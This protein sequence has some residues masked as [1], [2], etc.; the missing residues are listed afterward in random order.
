M[1][2]SVKVC[3]AVLFSVQ[4]LTVL[5]MLAY[6]LTIDGL[7]EKYGKTYRIKIDRINYVENGKC[8]FMLLDYWPYF[9]ALWDSNIAYICSESDGFYTIRSKDEVKERKDSD[10][11]FCFF[12]HRFPNNSEYKLKG[13][14]I[15]YNFYYGPFSET[16]NYIEIKVF[17]GNC[18]VERLY[19]GG[20]P[21]EEY[22]DKTDSDTVSFSQ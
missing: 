3:A 22:L 1:K 17:L 19:C 5:L 11:V 10:Y 9:N 21:I 6:G 16:D 14:S 8:D 7:V 15:N 2:K 12:R 13:D 4:I 18:V 20:V